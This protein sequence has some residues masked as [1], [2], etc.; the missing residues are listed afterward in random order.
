MLFLEEVYWQLKARSEWIMYGDKNSK[1]FYTAAKVRR[2]RNFVRVLKGE[3]RQW[4][5]DTKVLKS[6]VALFF[7]NLCQ[8]DSLGGDMNVI[9]KEAFSPLPIFVNEALTHNIE[10]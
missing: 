5:T 4:C 6:M 7:K 3:D 1:I 9:L 2:R 10:Y 8:D